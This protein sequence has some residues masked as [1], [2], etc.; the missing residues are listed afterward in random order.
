MFGIGITE[1]IV[2]LVI[3]LLLIGP[4]KLPELARTL[5]KGLSEFKN[6]AEDFRNSVRVDFNNESHSNKKII[7]EH[8]TIDVKNE[9]NEKEE[10]D[11]EKSGEE[12]NTDENNEDTTV[13][14]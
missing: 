13:E 1:I 3:A 9:K 2:I 5:G 4:D 7:E 14:K 8:T 12:R 10:K 6:A 11:K